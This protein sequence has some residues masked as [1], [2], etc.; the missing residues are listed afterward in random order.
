MR[1]LPVFEDAVSHTGY[2]NVIPDAVDGSFRS[3]PMVVEHEGEYAVPL[4]LSML[5]VHD[6]NPLALR[7]A[8]FGVESV[9]A[10]IDIDTRV[11]R[12]AT[13]TQLPGSR[14]DIPDTSRQRTSFAAARTRATFAP[15]SSY[16]V[17]VTAGAVADVR[18]TPF[19]PILPGVEMHATV[20]DNVLREDF[21]L[22]P[23]WIVLLEMAQIMTAAVLLGW[24]MGFS[25]GVRAALMAA[26]LTAGYLAWSQILFV[27]TGIPLGHRFPGGG[28]GA[29]LFRRRAPPLRV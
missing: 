1:N 22:R 16:L 19:D 17:G 20:I 12:R 6:G 14:A 18:V 7:L 11:R 15:T 26:T 10:R 3:V 21:L 24:V 2:F 29:H 23:S 28:D 25:R 8:D 27:H 4:S 5:R 9:Q 13:P